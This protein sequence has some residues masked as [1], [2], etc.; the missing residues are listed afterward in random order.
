MMARSNSAI[1]PED[2][3][4]DL[5]GLEID[6]RDIRGA[7]RALPAAAATIA[8]RRSLALTRRSLLAARPRREQR[9]VS[10]GI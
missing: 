3:N 1:P 8:E 4:G 7:S 5:T 6:E 9:S 10:D 2:I